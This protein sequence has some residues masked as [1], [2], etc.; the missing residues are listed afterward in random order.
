[1]EVLTIFVEYKNVIVLFFEQLHT[2]NSK[3]LTHHNKCINTNR[4]NSV[5]AINV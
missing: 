4:V 2:P 5:H 1:M 3:N